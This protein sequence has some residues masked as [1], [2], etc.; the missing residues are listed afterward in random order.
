MQY[1]QLLE[2]RNLVPPHNAPGNQ[3]TNSF[4]VF[5]DSLINRV[6]IYA[7][8]NFTGVAE[9]VAVFD[10]TSPTPVKVTLASGFSTALVS[11]VFS[12]VYR[13][14]IASAPY[15]RGG[16]TFTMSVSSDPMSPYALSVL[17]ETPNGYVT[18]RYTQAPFLDVGVLQP[19]T[20]KYILP[21]SPASIYGIAHSPTDLACVDDLR[22]A[23][24]TMFALDRITPIGNVSNVQLLPRDTTRTQLHDACT[25][26]YV[27]QP[28]QCPGKC[29]TSGSPPVLICQPFYIFITGAFNIPIN[30]TSPPS[31]T[32]FQRLVPAICNDF[33]CVHGDQQN[34]GLC[35][36]SPPYTGM[37]CDELV[38]LNGG[39]FVPAPA[40]QCVCPQQ[41]TGQVCE[42]Y[43]P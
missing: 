16:W 27:T 21:V 43:L 18:L 32:S 5:I 2:L 34:D 15:V 31:G 8:G 6:I 22:C 19:P 42:T 20:P 7:I 23:Q 3:Q 4:N 12:Y 1:M 38:C 9:P 28:F 17:G 26:Q 14:D 41:Y 33:H 10:A 24:V 37:Y 39:T 30:A 35:M 11:N 29:T 25:S 36:C 40:L 13:I